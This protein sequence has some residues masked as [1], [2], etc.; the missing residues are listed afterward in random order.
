M[1]PFI[2]S[3]A[4]FFQQSIALNAFRTALLA[5]RTIKNEQHIHS[6]DSLHSDE[7]KYNMHLDCLY[8]L[9]LTLAGHQRKKQSR[10]HFFRAATHF[11]DFFGL[12][13]ANFFQ[14]LVLQALQKPRHLQR[15]WRSTDETSWD[16]D[17]EIFT[18]SGIAPDT[19]STMQAAA[20]ITIVIRR[21]ILKTGWVALKMEN[22]LDVSRVSRSC[23]IAGLPEFTILRKLG[24]FYS[25]EALAVDWGQKQTLSS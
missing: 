11:G 10:W 4:S 2:S 23:L 14:Q 3:T 13:F 1:Y 20:K 25:A 5:F 18:L 16:M 21:V 7:C 12:Q 22:S 6:W 8:F 24:G 15:D 17:S 19:K 9:H